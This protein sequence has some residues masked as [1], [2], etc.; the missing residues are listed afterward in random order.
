MENSCEDLEIDYMCGSDGRTYTNL[1]YL[2]MAAC[3]T[4]TNIT[5]LHTG[6]CTAQDSQSI[7]LCISYEN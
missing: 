3:I 4:K 2:D 5:M 1:C 7:S 6:V